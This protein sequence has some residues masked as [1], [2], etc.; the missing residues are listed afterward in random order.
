MA[1]LNVILTRLCKAVERIGDLL[2]S[3]GKPAKPPPTGKRVSQHD[4]TAEF[5]EWWPHF[6]RKIRKPGAFKAYLAAI[7]RGA[8][9]EILISMAD[10]YHDAWPMER[11]KDGDYRMNGSTWLNQCM[12]ECDVSDFYENGSVPKQEK[13]L[14]E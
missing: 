8:K 7:K 9:Q 6:P 14:W 2:E 10:Y 5:E 4:Y 1:E 13:Q 12:Y 3:P 11:L